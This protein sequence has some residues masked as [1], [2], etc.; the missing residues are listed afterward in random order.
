MLC[1]NGRRAA[2]PARLLSCK[3]PP[4]PTW[5]KIDESELPVVT[6]ID[7]ETAAHLERLSL[8]D[9]SNE[10]AV[11]RLEDAIRFAD[12]LFVVDTTGVEP[13]DSVL[14]DRSLYL[15]KDEVTEGNCREEVMRNAVKTCEDYFVAPPGNIA[16]PD[17]EIVTKETEES[18]RRESKL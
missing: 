7:N 4:F 16:L 12:Q 11:S 10:E 2:A 9:F 8:V 15:R 14:E 17:R 6:K 13:M 3:V 18:E 5:K 1:R